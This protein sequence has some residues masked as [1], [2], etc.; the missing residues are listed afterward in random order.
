LLVITRKKGERIVIADNI[1]V[2]II[3][4]NRNRVRFGIQAPREIQI[5]TKLKA[6]PPT[7]PEEKDPSDESSG[8]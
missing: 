3:E 5:H 8:T 4:V 7:V 6:S 1:E 2:T